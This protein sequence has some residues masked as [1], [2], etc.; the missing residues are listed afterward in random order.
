[1]DN[2]SLF[3][4]IKSSYIINHIFSYIKDNDFK[5][6]LFLYSKKFQKELGI[7]LIG[8]KEKYL[9]KIG[10]DCYSRTLSK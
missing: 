8:L 10:F 5:E 9:K 6:K 4:T 2:E 7:N 3:N 1:M